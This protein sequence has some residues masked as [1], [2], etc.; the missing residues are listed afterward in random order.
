M[1]VEFTQ[2][3]YKPGFI[4]DANLV[5]NNLALLALE[6]ERNARGIVPAAG[7]H[8]GDDDGA[9]MGVHF[10]GRDDDARAGLADL[11]AFGGIEA[12]EVD[13]ETGDYQ[14][15]SDLS[16]LAVIATSASRSLSSLCCAIPENASDQPLRAK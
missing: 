9:D 12:D 14:R 11:V 4:N 5:E 6:R 7:S 15:H 16:H 2:A 1:F 8:G 3:L 13:V 10:V